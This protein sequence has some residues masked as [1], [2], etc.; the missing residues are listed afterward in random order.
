MY[1]DKLLIKEKLDVYQHRDSQKHGR[2]YKEMVG[3]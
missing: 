1:S 2:I 3:C